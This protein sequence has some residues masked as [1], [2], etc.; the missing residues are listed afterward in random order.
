MWL[1]SYIQDILDNRYQ[2][3]RNI[4]EV[5]WQII[6]STERQSDML[7]TF[8]VNLQHYESLYSNELL[9]HF[10]N[11]LRIHNMHSTTFSMFSV[12]LHIHLLSTTFS[13]WTVAFDDWLVRKLWP[14]H[15]FPSNAEIIFENRSYNIGTWVWFLVAFW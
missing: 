5:K 14:C 8:R 3:Y 4:G 1:I 12:L 2:I 9:D 13:L 6:F 15:D 7:L 10:E 11:Y